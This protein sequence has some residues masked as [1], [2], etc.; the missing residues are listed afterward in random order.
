LYDDE[1]EEYG[2]SDA[3]ALGMQF[4]KG[5][6]PDLFAILKFCECND[7]LVSNGTICCYFYE[8]DRLQGVSNTNS[9]N[10]IVMLY[11]NQS[12]ME[13]VPLLAT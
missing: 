8:N 1:L 10:K 5:V 13:N 12:L 6:L 2:R 7:G 11:K 4:I 9:E 3:I